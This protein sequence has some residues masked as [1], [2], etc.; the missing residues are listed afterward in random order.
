MGR[1]KDMLIEQQE[2]EAEQM[3][4]EHLEC[5]YQRQTPPEELFMNKEEYDAWVQYMEEQHKK[6]GVVQV[7]IDTSDIVTQEDVNYFTEAL[8]QIK[9]GEGND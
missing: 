1:I 9:K 6:G 4:A 5:E 2:R 8:N 7:A 3:E